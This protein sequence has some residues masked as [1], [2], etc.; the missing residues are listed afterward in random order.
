M[1]KFE[2][3][4][5][6]ENVNE[7]INENIDEKENDP[8]I[9]EQI[10]PWHKRKFKKVLSVIG[11]SVLAGIIFG[12]AAR[13]VFKYSDSLISKIFGLNEPYDHATAEPVTLSPEKDISDFPEK[14]NVVHIIQD[15][16]EKTVESNDSE[17]P[18]KNPPPEG[19]IPT[20]IGP[21]KDAVEAMHKTA[22]DVKRG[23]LRINSVTN[24]VNW[25]GEKIE[26]TESMLG[27]VVTE[28]SSDLF[29]LS[30]YDKLANADRVDLVFDTGNTYTVPIVGFDESYN[31]AVLLL[32]KQ[33]LNQDD[34]NNMKSL[35]I[36]TSENIYPGM[37]VI[38]LESPDG[39]AIMTEYGYITSCEYVEYITDASI[40][41][42]TTSLGLKDDAEGIITDIDGKVIGIMCR[43]IGDSIKAD[44]NKC[45]KV[46]SLVK[47]TEK[48]CNGEPRVYFG[49][50]VEDIPA[51]ALKENNI[52]NGIYVNNVEPS[53]P[54]SDA[55]IR[56]GD[57]ITAING[58][59][60]RNVSDFTDFLMQI[61]ENSSITVELYRAS[62]SADQKF[63]VS[64]RPIN[65]NN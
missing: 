29:I 48:L 40:E 59:A 3:K 51:W 22:E 62:K 46:N 1:D 42:F 55:G 13:F 53:S 44:V 5:I 50:N 18:E 60:I 63:V 49:V 12:V 23:I 4:D 43:N 15:E 14:D 6:K 7:S 32:S 57:F 27:I 47:V 37:P 45:M 33:S 30:Y 9:Q 20:G 34:L 19:G 28:N 61:S 26:Q 10:K 31:I 36:G 54:A 41:L 58:G 65:R 25:L 21:Y 39:A 64:V 56:K 35:S 2:K 8:V 11:L 38:G 16:P 17:N 52:D 24:V